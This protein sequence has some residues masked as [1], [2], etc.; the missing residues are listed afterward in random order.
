MDANKKRREEQENAPADDD[1]SNLLSGDE[2]QAREVDVEEV[3]R[4]LDYMTHKR[5]KKETEVKQ[6]PEVYKRLWGGVEK[7]FKKARELSTAIEGQRRLEWL[8][9]LLSSN[10]LHLTDK[11][12]LDM[13]RQLA[14]YEDK[15]HSVKTTGLLNV[16]NIKGPV[17]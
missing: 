14:T 8:K 10:H 6:L 16:T 7:K 17:H 4:A 5:G 1:S 2:L 13:L 3:Q 11:K 15:L 9:L 12:Q